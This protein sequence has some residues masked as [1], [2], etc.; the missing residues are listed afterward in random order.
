MHIV[1]NGKAKT[2]PANT[3]LN[4]I[5]KNSCRDPRHAIA[6]LNGAIV[7]SADWEQTVIHDG[8]KLELVTLV[9]GG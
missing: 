2:F 3:R 8:D 9:G 1:I 6:E 4:A 7:K 5:I